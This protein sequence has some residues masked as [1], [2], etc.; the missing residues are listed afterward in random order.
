M[1]EIPFISEST[2][3]EVVLQLSI[4]ENAYQ[5]VL[6]RLQE[7][8]PVL[9]G[10]LFSEN[11]QVF[12]QSEKE[13][14]LYLVL[15]IWQSINTQIQLPSSSVNEQSLSE[16]EEK[17]WNILQKVNARNFRDRLNVF[18]ENYPQ[19]DL[20]A[21]AED[22]LTDDTDNLV[23]SEAREHLFII[24]KSIIDLLVRCKI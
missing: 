1:S 19:E 17:N 18:F 16:A 14:V 8:E 6:E 20:L 3:D 4:S 15:V 23:T 10:Y 2:I 22:A 5:Q 11:F 24:L 12:T 21:F 7:A 13:Y 9:L